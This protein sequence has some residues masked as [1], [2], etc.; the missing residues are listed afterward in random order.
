MA[1]KGFNIK[2][3]TDKLTCQ[4]FLD[5]GV[6][7][8]IMKVE[9]NNRKHVGR[10]INKV[11]KFWL[12][13]QISSTVSA[14][15]DLLIS[16]GQLQLYW[17]CFTTQSYLHESLVTWAPNFGGI[18][19]GE[20]DSDVYKSYHSYFSSVITQYVIFANSIDVFFLCNYIKKNICMV[21]GENVWPLNQ[22]SST[23][24]ALLDLLINFG[25]FQ[26]YW[27]CFTT[28]SY[29]HEW[30]GHQTLVEY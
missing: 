2:D 27:L 3:L 23:V 5:P 11:K 12:L 30:R 26:F 6:N 25:Q 9:K 28:Q 10:F 7:L 19:V 29:L 8:R 18:L 14:V 22:N 17:L 1:D 16:C 13:N 15:F 21:K 20:S 24:S 4:F